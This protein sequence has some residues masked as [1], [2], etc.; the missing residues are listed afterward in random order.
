MTAEGGLVPERRQASDAYAYLVQCLD[1]MCAVVETA[2]ASHG[3]LQ[4]AWWHS[5]AAATS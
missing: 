2:L 4:V 5:D 3:E 1:C